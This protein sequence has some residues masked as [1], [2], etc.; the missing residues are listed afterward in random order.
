M[1]T[2]IEKNVFDQDAKCSNGLLLME[3]KHS[4]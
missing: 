3:F 1:K 2:E 4:E